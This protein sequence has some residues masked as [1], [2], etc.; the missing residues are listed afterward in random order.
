MSD[1]ETIK[2]PLPIL[3]R[4]RMPAHVRDFLLLNA[5]RGHDIQDL[6]IKLLEKEAAKKGFKPQ[7]FA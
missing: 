2:H 1:A 4:D 3:E 5:M 6:I 7:S